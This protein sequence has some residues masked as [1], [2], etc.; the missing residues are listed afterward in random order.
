MGQPAA[1]SGSIAPADGGASTAPAQGVPGEPG[2]EAEG[3]GF[4][5]FIFIILLWGA[6]LY[7]FFIRPQKRKDKERK[8]KISAIGKGD[9]VVTIG[10]IQGTVTAINEESVT[11][12]VDD[13][14]GATLKFVRAAVNDIVKP[15][16]DKDKDKAG[17][18]DDGGDRAEMPA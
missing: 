4:Q 2:P 18:E 13:K 16:K 12:R 9:K 1:D 6:V 3:G 7:F 5:S 17:E 8:E 11:L 14:T 15:A 10:G